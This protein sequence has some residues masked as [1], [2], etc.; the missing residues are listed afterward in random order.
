MGGPRNLPMGQRFVFP[1]SYNAKNL[2]QGATTEMI[3]ATGNH[4][5]LRRDPQRNLQEIR[6]PHGHWIRFA[7]DDPVPY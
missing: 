6:T 5:E 3:D 7:Y 1:E 2:A 4:L